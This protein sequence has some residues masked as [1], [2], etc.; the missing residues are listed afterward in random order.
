[1]GRSGGAVCLR[2]GAEN[3][4]VFKEMNSALKKRKMF[5]H[6]LIFFVSQFPL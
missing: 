6:E 4:K 1:M 3:G 2:V 5:F